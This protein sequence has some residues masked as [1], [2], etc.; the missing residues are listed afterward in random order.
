MSISVLFSSTV[1]HFWCSL[2][3]PLS[4][5]FQKT[6]SLISMVLIKPRSASYIVGKDSTTGFSLSLSLSLSLSR[7]L[8]HSPSLR[9]GLIK[10]S[11]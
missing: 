9:Q 2:V 4:I 5:Q 6:V 3:L 7:S 11:G 10:F 1:V 8:P